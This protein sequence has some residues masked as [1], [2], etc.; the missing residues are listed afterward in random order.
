V[1][2]IVLDIFFQIL[3]ISTKNLLVL[4]VSGFETRTSRI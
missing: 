3:T 1:E 2:G 4:P